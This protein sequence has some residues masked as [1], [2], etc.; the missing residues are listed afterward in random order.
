MRGLTHLVRVFLKPDMHAF[1][2]TKTELPLQLWTDTCEELVTSRVG[3]DVVDRWLKDGRVLR[4]EPHEMEVGLPTSI[5]VNWVETYYRT[6]LEKAVR[7]LLGTKV[8]VTLTAT[9]PKEQESTPSLDALGE[10]EM[11][12]LRQNVEHLPSAKLKS[13]GL[14]LDH[15]FLTFV[16]GENNQYCRAVAGSVAENPG[17]RYNP[18]LFHGPTGMGKTHLMTAIG[19]DVLK[20]RPKA[21]VLYVTGEQ[22]TNEFIEAVQAGKLPGF[23]TRYRRMDLLLIDDVHFLAGKD[24][25]QEEFFHT[26]NAHLNG[27]SQVVLTSDRPPNEIPQ[28]EKRLVSRFDRGICAAMR[29]PSMETRLAILRQ[30]AQEWEVDFGQEIYH[31][32]ASTVRRNVRRLEGALL[33]L[34]SH[35][36]LHRV[37]MTLADAKRYLADLV[38]EEERN[39]LVTVSEIQRCVAA[40]FEVS[41]DDLNGRRRTTQIVHPRQ[42]AMYLARDL[43][44]ASLKEIGQS[45]GG[46][47]HGTVIHAC[48]KIGEAIQSEPETR[49]IVQFLKDN[50]LQ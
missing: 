11:A 13:A 37:P 4:L 29:A 27:G 12:L 49:R 42:I 20:R 47:D 6:D 39:S 2:D 5:H 48:K 26:Y 21:K 3:Q 34:S 8:Q 31:Y 7:K 15:T 40:Y 1:N 19:H 50:L 43:T 18:V 36:P 14:N 24:A 23:R 17:G 25:T 35:A 22:F 46:R 30:K 38:M 16:V 9:A 33:S 10:K 28:L 32:I 44:N 45:F 41:P